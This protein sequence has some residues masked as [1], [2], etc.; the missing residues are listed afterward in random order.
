MG[1]VYSGQISLV[2]IENNSV[3]TFAKDIVLGEIMELCIL[4]FYLKA[5]PG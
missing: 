4:M 3:V 1:A 2:L 5:I